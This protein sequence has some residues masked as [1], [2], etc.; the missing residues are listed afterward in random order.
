MYN[1]YNLSLNLY[2]SRDVK[3][4]NILYKIL[5]EIDIKAKHIIINNLNL[6]HSY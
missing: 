1:I 2:F 3:I 6:Y 5:K 4:L